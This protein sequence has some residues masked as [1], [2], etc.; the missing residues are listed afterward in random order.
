M[1]KIILFAIPM[2]LTVPVAVVLCRS[3]IAR[4]VRV[5]FGTVFFSAFVAAFFWLGLVT[6][7]DIYTLDYWRGSVPKPPDRPLML[8]AVV[9][10]IITCS[11][12]AVAVVHHY[13]KQTKP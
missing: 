11:L 12:P 1:Q 7:G 6:W 3:R 13:Q 8:K 5:S 10:M 9:F 4:K 2:L